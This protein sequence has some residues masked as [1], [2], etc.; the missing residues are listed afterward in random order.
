[1]NSNRLAFSVVR[2]V[3]GR[4]L[5]LRLTPRT[6]LHVREY[7]SCLSRGVTTSSAPLCNVAANFNSL[8]DGGVSPSRLNALRRGLVGDRTY[9][10]KRRVHPIVVGLVVLFGTRT[11][12]LKR[13]N[14]RIVAIRHV[15]SFFGG[16]IVP[17]MCSHNSLKTSNSLTPLT[18]LFL[19][20]VKINSI[21]CGKGG[22][23]T[24]DIL[25]RFK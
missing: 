5:G 19:P 7:H 9:D 24:V 18:G 8:Y 6:G 21:G 2:H 12:S 3:V 25:S 16:S 13:D 1:M 17:V 10:I 23:R 4:G 11:L 20:L 14:I 15:L 22:H